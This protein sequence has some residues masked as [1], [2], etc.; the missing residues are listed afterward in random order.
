LLFFNN[1]RLGRKIRNSVIFYTFG[2]Q[3]SRLLFNILA[4]L[5]R[6]FVHFIPNLPLA[7]YPNSKLTF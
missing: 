7:F 2:F 4:T 5:L 1:L 3:R 6:L